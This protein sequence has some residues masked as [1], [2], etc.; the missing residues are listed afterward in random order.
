MGFMKGAAKAGIGTVK[1]VGKAA[2]SAAAVPGYAASKFGTSIIKNAAKAPGATI[3]TIAGAGA[4]GYAL[5]DADGDPNPSKAAITAGLGA[6]MAS[7]VPGMAAAGSAAVAL[8]IGAGAT[9]AGFLTG[10]GQKMVKMPSEPVSFSNMGELKFSALGSS[11]LL[12]GAAVEGTR[13]AVAKFEQGRM[14]RHDGM[15]HTLT[16][17]IPQNTNA[18]YANN[19]G[20]TGDLVFSLY[21]NR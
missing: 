2:W 16:P 13:R 9:G 21:N 20:A 5:S 3:A 17:Q 19:G 7:A 11:L 8:G 12:G 14:G 18:S 1:G 10:L 15:V 4:L 6:T